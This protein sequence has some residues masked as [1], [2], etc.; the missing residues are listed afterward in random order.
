M[1]ETKMPDS[2]V[3]NNIISQKVIKVLS[4]I[5]TSTHSDTK[6][7]LN[8]QVLNMGGIINHMYY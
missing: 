5:K 3:N 4:I 7:T 2:V 1:K 8:S 6:L